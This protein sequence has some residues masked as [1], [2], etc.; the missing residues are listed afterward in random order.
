MLSG[1]LLITQL[2]IQK[3]LMNFFVILFVAKII[4]NS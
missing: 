2:Y 1:Y 3:D 4:M